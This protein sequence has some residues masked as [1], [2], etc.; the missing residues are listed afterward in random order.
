LDEKGDQVLL[1]EPSE[2]E[3]IIAEGYFKKVETD[4]A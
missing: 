3:E 4:I 1:Y 2:I